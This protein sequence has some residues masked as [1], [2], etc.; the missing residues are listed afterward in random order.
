M[1]SVIFPVYNRKDKV[2][3]LHRRLVA[4]LFAL[5]EPYEIIAVDRGSHDGARQFLTTL[6]PITAVLLSRDFGENAALDAGLHIALGDFVITIDGGM[7]Y[8]PEDIS[9]IFAKLKE[10]YGAVSGWRK[11]R[12][13]SLVRRLFSFIANRAASR[14]TGV[15]L[16]DFNCALKG[17]RRE[18]IDGIQLLGDTSIFLPVFAYDRGARIAEVPISCTEEKGGHGRRT[19]FEMAHFIFDVL[20]VSFLLNYFSHPLRFFGKWALCS[21]F[22]AAVAFVAAA[23]LKIAGQNDFSTTPLPLMATMFVILSVILFMLGIIT[24]IL[25][26]IYYERKDSTP[27]MVYEVVKNRKNI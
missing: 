3:Q 16:H 20:S 1:I 9:L 14:I 26:R 19:L 6:S 21:G 13:D 10:G 24:E 8:R 27:Y 22:L 5:G 18:F 2:A 7:A 23:A 15:R 12:T 4:A 25:L 11:G 17:Y